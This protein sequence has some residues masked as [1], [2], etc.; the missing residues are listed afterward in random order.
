MNTLARASRMA[1]HRFAACIAAVVTA[2]VC[3][4]DARADVTDTSTSYDGSDRLLIQGKT[5]TI[6]SGVTIKVGGNSSGACNFIGVDA[7]NSTVIID[8]GK[9]WCSQANSTDQL[10]GDLAIGIN[11]QNITGTL[12]LQ[13]GELQVDRYLRSGVLWGYKTKSDA[14][15]LNGQNSHG[16]ININGGTANVGTFYLGADTSSTGSSTLNLSGGTLT[17]GSLCFLPYNGQAFNWGSGTLVAANNNIF[18]LNTYQGGST[19][20]RT[21]QIT[22]SPSV[23]NAA[24]FGITVPDGFTG[25]GTLRITGG[26]NVFFAASSVTYN[27]QVASDGVVHLG[28]LNSVTP[29]LT[30]PAF[31]AENGATL[32]FAL[33]DSPSGRYPLVAS[34]SLPADASGINFSCN[35]ASGQLEIDNGVLYFVFGAEVAEEPDYLIQSIVADG[36]QYIDTGIIGKGGTKIE[37]TGLMYEASGSAGNHV[38]MGCT[39]TSGGAV[40]VPMQG[41]GTVAE[42]WGFTVEGATGE[43][44]PCTETYRGR[45]GVVTAEWATNGSF[46]LSAGGS[47]QTWTLDPAVV[48]V[49]N[50]LYLC[51]SNNNGT[52]GFNNAKAVC[53]GLKI[54]QVPEGGSEYVLVRNFQPCVKNGKACLFDAAHDKI[55][56][57]STGIDFIAGSKANAQ[58]GLVHRYSFTDGFSDSVG[59]EDATT[60]NGEGVAVADGKAT[61]S[62]ANGV[63]RLGSAGM[64]GTTG[65]ATI[66]IWGKPNFAA[67]QDTAWARAFEYGWGP[68]S[69]ALFSMMWQSDKNLGNAFRDSITF[70]WNRNTGASGFGNLVG[71]LSGQ[72]GSPYSTTEMN[73][74]SATF[75]TDANGSTT[76]TCR[77]YDSESGEFKTYS[78]TIAGW[79]IADMAAAYLDLGGANWDGII[80]AFDATYDEVRIYDRAVPGGLLGLNVQLGPDTL[81]VSYDAD[82]KANVAIPAGTTV[83]VNATVFGN[84]FTMDGTVTLGEGSK[85]RFDSANCGDSGMSFTAEGGFVVPSGAI[86]DYVELT[87]NNDY[88]VALMN[89]GKTIMVTPDLNSVVIAHWTGAAGTGDPADPGNWACTNAFNAGVSGGLP[90]STSAVFIDGT[91]ALTFPADFEMN[92]AN[93]TFGANGG[94]VTL[95]NDCDWSAFASVNLSNGTTLD[96]NGHDLKAVTI[97]SDGTASVVNTATGTKPTLW[98][99]DAS[100]ETDLVGSGV[101]VDTEAIEI[102]VVNGANSNFNFSRDNIAGT[103]DATFV[104]NGG[105]VT[106]TLELSIGFAG[107]YGIYE[108]NDGTLTAKGNLVPGG[109]NHGS[110]EFRQY[111]GTVNANNYFTI[112]YYGGKGTYVITGGTLNVTKRAVV[113]GQNEG[114]ENVAGFFDIAGGTVNAAKQILLGEGATSA[115][116][117]RVRNGGVVCTSGIAPNGGANTVEFDG[118]TVKATAASGEFMKNL[119]NVVFAAGGLNLDANGF[120]LGIS[121]CVLKAAMGAKAITFAGAGT[122]AFT[123]T[124]LELS[125][126]TTESYVF[127]EATGEGTFT[128]VP[129]LNLKGW[130]VKLSTDSKKVIIDRN[131]LMIIL[132]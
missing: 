43:G 40:F 116:T 42:V 80:T 17:V 39:M 2:F 1:G 56:Y 101:S 49:S 70:N 98:R 131:G 112:G 72:T 9:L 29:A 64:L 95:A 68:A 41:Y 109:R 106:N 52:P 30:T 6:P 128:S 12:T 3:A 23:L 61:T 117:L 86:T 105:N 114:E 103:W 87:E 65:S 54:W 121:N 111:G 22:G 82:G 126:K 113:V 24:G 4:P 79:S 129:S 45:W 5:V 88:D 75:A 8:G 34:E 44:N 118:G 125:G 67:S 102:K 35:G 84:T 63:L 21:M 38:L 16:V 51:N 119:T 50:T 18:V 58:T 93:V 90:G 13:S 66:E 53:G 122:L 7:G 85:L 20:S 25:T 99:E 73:Y 11:N 94:Q 62:A 127:A 19:L 115:G 81:A 28:T 55:Y 69:T 60:V 48:T 110:G 104:Q 31:S 15:I 83:P 14:R 89:D 124:T 108:M 96:L 92:W 132:R 97:A 107:H 76:M 27:V 26:G 78:H 36:N 71:K 100:H 91:T 46:T 130:S 74:M 33:P 57:S 37:F 123:D 47:S 59:G 10:F 77:R 32:K 120:S